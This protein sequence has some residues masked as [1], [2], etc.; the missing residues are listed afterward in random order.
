VV[1]A[2]WSNLPVTT[3][4][5]SMQMRIVNKATRTYGKFIDFFEKKSSRKLVLLTLLT[6]LLISCFIS[7]V[8]FPD[9]DAGNLSFGFWEHLFVAVLA[10]PVIETYLAQE[11]IIG[12]VLKM[13][14]DAFLPACLLS[15]FL[16]GIAHHYSI[17]YIVKACITGFLYASLYIIMLKKGKNA[18]IPVFIAHAAYN[19]IGVVIIHFTS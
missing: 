14:K 7:Y 15:A 2:F 13:K 9:A 6:N 4:Y 12:F 10:A 1:S 3:F 5:F 11:L 18:F 19:F 17:P 16:F 8:L